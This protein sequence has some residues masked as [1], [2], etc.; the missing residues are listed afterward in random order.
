MSYPK[1]PTNMSHFH[2]L[3]HGVP[4]EFVPQ[5]EASGEPD[6]T[7]LARNAVLAIVKKR[8][9][10]GDTEA[11][12]LLVSLEKQPLEYLDIEL[13]FG[14]K[15]HKY[16]ISSDLWPYIKPGWSQYKRNNVIYIIERLLDEN[17]REWMRER[18]INQPYRPIQN[19][20]ILAT[21][22][23][24]YLI[25]AVSPTHV[26]LYRPRGHYDGIIQSVI[27]YLDG[28]GWTVDEWKP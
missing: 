3:Y 28:Q 25:E 13:Y 26:K 14:L 17:Q 23:D 8:A 7:L 22:W 12:E 1:I 5:A 24:E 11:C 21:A 15:D 27:D 4:Q 18:L 19:K 9:D 20:P 2:K 10:K 6:Y 16:K